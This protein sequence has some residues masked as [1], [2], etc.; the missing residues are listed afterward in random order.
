MRVLYNFQPSPSFFYSVFLSRLQPFSSSHPQIHR[1]SDTL[2]ANVVHFHRHSSICFPARFATAIRMYTWMA[3]TF[4]NDDE[5]CWIRPGCGMF[6]TFKLI[7]PVLPLQFV[8][9]FFPFSHTLSSTLLEFI[10]LVWYKCCTT[11]TTIHT[12]TSKLVSQHSLFP[13]PFSLR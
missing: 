9:S 13:C 11:S 3:K 2:H 12:Y 10:R 8:L 1:T 4:G 7:F 5:C 6:L